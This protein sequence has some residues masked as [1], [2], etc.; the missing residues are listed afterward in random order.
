MQLALCDDK[1]TGQIILT[2]YECDIHPTV[3]IVYA[4]IW[5]VLFQGKYGRQ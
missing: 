5:E 4:T 3:R 1:E 2:Y